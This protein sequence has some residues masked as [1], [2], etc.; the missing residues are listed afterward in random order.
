MQIIGQGATGMRCLAL[1][2]L[3]MAVLMPA[4]ALAQNPPSSSCDQLRMRVRDVGQ[5]LKM[6]KAER[7]ELKQFV[8]LHE[9]DLKVCLG[10]KFDQLKR[11]LK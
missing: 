3:S 5:L 7:E 4:Q 2:A 10:H 8:I 6:T 9:S 1:I 11:F